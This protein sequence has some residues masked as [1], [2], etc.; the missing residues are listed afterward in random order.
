MIINRADGPEERG[1]NERCMGAALPDFGN[2][3]G[4]SYRRIVQAPGQIAMFYEAAG[5][6]AWQRNIPM[7][8]AP[9]LPSTIRQ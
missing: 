2:F 4:G 3:V 1:L 6:G 7:T 5:G 8:T 9:H